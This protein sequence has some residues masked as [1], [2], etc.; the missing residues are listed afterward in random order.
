[1]AI[2]VP[3]TFNTPL[4]KLKWIMQALRD[5]DNGCPWDIEQS[6]E[7]IAPHTIEEAYEVVDAIENGTKDDLKEEL[8]DLL[9]Q[10]IFYTQLSSEESLFDF[11]DVVNQVADKMISRHPHVFGDVTLDNSNDIH[12]VW[13]TQKSKE[14][15]SNSALDNI[16]RALPALLRAQKIQKK[17]AKTG[18][19]WKNTD[20]ALDKFKEEL[21]EFHEAQSTEDKEEE[22]GDM[23]F[24]L[25]NYGRMYGIH[26]EES[27]RKANEK[28]INRFQ[29]M[30]KTTDLN[31]L[32]LDQMLK[33]WQEVKK[34]S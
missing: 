10:V 13:D 31:N 11:D 32:S 3:T 14:K 24:A 5:K 23:L 6:Y 16:T 30:E 22:F 2:N 17:A 15:E 4:D 19:E 12:D 25:V 18:F 28:F 27:L 21:Q 1:M 33:A 29:K 7:T 20:Q 26:T 8:G 9:F 34:L